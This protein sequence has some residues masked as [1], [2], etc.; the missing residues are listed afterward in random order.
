MAEDFAG[1]IA[2]FLQLGLRLV[3][4]GDVEHEAA[5]LHDVARRHRA[6]QNSS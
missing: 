5:V 3:K 1:E 6:W 4:A 2:L